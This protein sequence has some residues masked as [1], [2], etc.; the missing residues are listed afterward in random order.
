MYLSVKLL[1]YLTAELERL[2]CGTGFLNR[3]RGIHNLFIRAPAG[4][5]RQLLCKT[6]TN[7]ERM[8]KQ[9]HVCVSTTTYRW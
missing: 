9:E 1:I 5:E 8:S 4:N 7:G 3:K 2:N 6:I